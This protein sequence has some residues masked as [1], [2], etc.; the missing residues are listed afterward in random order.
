[1]ENSPSLGSR[2]R[3]LACN[4]ATY[5][6]GVCTPTEALGERAQGFRYERMVDDS[7]K[8]W[9]DAQVALSRPGEV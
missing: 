2:L 7:L 9:Q 3:G 1:M 4:T 8:E 6:K 5:P